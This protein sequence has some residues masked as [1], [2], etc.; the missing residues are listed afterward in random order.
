MPQ[1]VFVE[2]LAGCLLSSCA[3]FA[4]L[5]FIDFVVLRRVH[6]LTSYPPAC[7]PSRTVALFATPFLYPTCPPMLCP[8]PL[9]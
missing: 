5:N 7:F 8:M 3:L 9:L 6:T 2:A 4:F 1:R